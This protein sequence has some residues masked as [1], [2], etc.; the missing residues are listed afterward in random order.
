MAKKSTLTMTGAPFANQNAEAPGP[1]LSRGLHTIVVKI[2]LSA[3][4]WF[5][6]VM[7]LN[8]S[9]GPKLGLVLDLAI[10][11]LVM[12][13]TLLLVVNDPRLKQVRGSISCSLLHCHHRC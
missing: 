5:L 9:G 4:A 11:A 10:G 7:W 12:V 13:F 6:A 2:A 8:F 3:V 1:F